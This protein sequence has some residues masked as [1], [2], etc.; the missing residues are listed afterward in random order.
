MGHLQAPQRMDLL[1]FQATDLFPA[2]P[3]V[4]TE[5][6]WSTYYLQILARVRKAL[7]AH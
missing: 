3:E 7:W 2:H 4:V 6:E 5:P 1:H